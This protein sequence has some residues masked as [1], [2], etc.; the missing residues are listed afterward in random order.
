MERAC[1]LYTSYSVIYQFCYRRLNGDTDTAADITQ[2]VFL[3]LL[4]NIHTVRTVSYTH[5]TY[6]LTGNVEQ[7]RDFFAALEKTSPFAMGFEAL[8]GSIKPCFCPLFRHRGPC[9]KAL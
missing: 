7:Y 4:E 1:L 3:K 8:S 5:L 9:R 2:D 6:E